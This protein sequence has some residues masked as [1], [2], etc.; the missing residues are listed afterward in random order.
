MN[1]QQTKQELKRFITRFRFL[2]LVFAF[3]FNS[4]FLQLL[5]LFEV[6]EA[7]TWLPKMGSVDIEWSYGVSRY[8]VVFLT[9]PPLK[10]SKYKKVNL[11]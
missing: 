11:G 7:N 9:G 1:I 3:F 5:K 8:R 6:A 4:C 2:A 10:S